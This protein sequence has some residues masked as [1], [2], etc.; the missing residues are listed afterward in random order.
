MVALIKV[1]V[2]ALGPW[3]NGNENLAGPGWIGIVALIAAA[4]MT[5]GN[6]AALAQKNL[7]RLLAYSSIAHAGY[8]LVGVLAVIVSTG[9]KT[10]AGPVLFYLVVYSIANIGAFSVAVWLFRDKQSDHQN[11]KTQ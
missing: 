6:F 1:L 3:A 11:R 2:Q 5:Y 7:K 10:S 8:M 4:T 9:E